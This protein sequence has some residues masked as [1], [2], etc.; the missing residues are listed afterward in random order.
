MATSRLAIRKQT[1]QTWRIRRRR[2]K[3]PTAGAKMPGHC[4]GRERIEE[5]DETIRRPR[6]ERC[7]TGPQ[8]KPHAKGPVKDIG[9]GLAA[10]RT[11]QGGHATTQIAAQRHGRKRPL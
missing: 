2:T 9:S 4:V 1:K 6:R 11:D 7:L 10:M 8:A 3:Q 5:T